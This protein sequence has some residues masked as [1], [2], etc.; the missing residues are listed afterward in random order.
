MRNNFLQHHSKVIMLIS[1]ILIPAVLIFF[2]SSAGWSEYNFTGLLNSPHYRIITK[3]SACVILVWINFLL[4][5]SFKSRDDIL[6]ISFDLL[7]IAAVFIPYSS[8]ESILSSL[9]LLSSYSAFA[10][11][12]IILFPR[13]ASHAHVFTLY[14][15]V[16]VL[17]F[18]ICFTEG[19]ITGI[20]EVIYACMCSAVLCILKN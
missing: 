2:M 13:I 15:S 16:S 12:N 10:V 11:F 19:Q 6:C 17:C 14:L 8:S 7:Y 3:I 18:L 5:P 1:F 4:W 9:H 20:S